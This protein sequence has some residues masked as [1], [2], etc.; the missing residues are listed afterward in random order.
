MMQSLESAQENSL[1]LCYSINTFVPVPINL[2]K[3]RL[4]MKFCIFGIMSQ[5]MKN[6]LHP[7]Q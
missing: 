7:E 6:L 5:S 4:K 2:S 3:D 1:G